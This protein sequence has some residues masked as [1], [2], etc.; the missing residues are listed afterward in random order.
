[1]SDDR[2]RPEQY[3]S[4]RDDVL[5]RWIGDTVYPYS[6]EL[7]TSLDAAGLGR[8]GV[9]TAAD[10][11]RLPPVTLADLGDGTSF[12]LR[13]TAEAVAGFAPVGERLRLQIADAL[14]RRAELARRRFDP[15]HKPVVWTAHD[16]AGH[17]VLTASTTTDLDRLA[18]LGRRALAI[19]GVVRTD[20]VLVLDPPGAGIG[21]WQLLLGCREAGVAVLQLG[22]DPDR[23]VVEA[24]RPTVVAGRSDAVACLVAAGLPDTVGRLLVHDAADDRHADVLAGPGLPV[25]EWWAP[26]A[27][28]AAWVRCPGGT[29][30]HTWPIHEL[31][32]IVDPAGA[33]TERGELVWSAVGWHGSVWLRVRTGV[34]ATVAPGACPS[35]RRTTPRVE[36]IDLLRRRRR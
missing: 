29:G 12:A 16:A 30:F 24:A 35:C 6:T 19:S 1:M 21:S 5:R 23:R 20:R 4:A 15:D 31:V 2:R 36:R 8:R 13:P 33:A 28:R 26:P 22:Q 17:A 7:R 27:A 10:L 9:R 34:T 14:G 25:A 18:G 11:R 3:A 32:E